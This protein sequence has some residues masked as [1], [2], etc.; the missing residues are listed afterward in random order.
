MIDDFGGE[1]GIL[2]RIVDQESDLGQG[3]SFVG[4]MEAG[5]RGEPGAKEFKHGEPFEKKKC[6]ESLRERWIP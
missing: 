1:V 3:D 4:H 2:F 5:G 6:S